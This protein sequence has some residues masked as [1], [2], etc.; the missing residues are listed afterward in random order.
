MW[1]TAWYTGQGDENKR[2]CS[3]FMYYFIDFELPLV[4]S[5]VA[6]FCL[7]NISTT[8]LASIPKANYHCGNCAQKI[9]NDSPAGVHHRHDI[10]HGNE[11]VFNSHRGPHLEPTTKVFSICKLRTPKPKGHNK[12]FSLLCDAKM[13]CV[14]LNEYTF[15]SHMMM[16]VKPSFNLY[17][18]YVYDMYLVID[19]QWWRCYIC[20]ELEE[21]CRPT[22]FCF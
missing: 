3:S 14:S 9:S 21:P 16:W 1:C 4:A 17:D 13:L 19:E 7:N 11:K 12:D 2:C 18:I 6:V 22:R 5:I 10:C 15:F 20:H 8:L